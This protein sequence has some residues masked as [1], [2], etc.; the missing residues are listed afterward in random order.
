MASTSDPPAANQNQAP[1]DR[2]VLPY[3]TR[4]PGTRL[5]CNMRH[6]V[7]VVT[8]APRDP[9]TACTRALFT[10][11]EAGLLAVLTPF[12][13]LLILAWLT[14]GV[15]RHRLHWLLAAALLL[16][17]AMMGL[18]LWV[19]LR[20]TRFTI[21]RQRFTWQRAGAWPCLGA[22]RCAPDQIARVYVSDDRLRV[23]LR[24]GTDLLAGTAPEWRDIDPAELD[25]LTAVLRSALQL[26]DLRP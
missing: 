19:G 23:C 22:R 20:G 24:D 16:V 3:S 7:L 10:W 9:F 8:V 15:P 13:L 1:P 17:A 11:G 2:A 18:S 5:T 21:S 26:G 6:E 12:L 14:D 4:P 25:W